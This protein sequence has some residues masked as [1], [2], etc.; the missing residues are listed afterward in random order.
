MKA[1]GYVESN[2]RTDSQ[3]QLTALDDTAARRAPDNINELTVDIIGCKGVKARQRG[4][5]VL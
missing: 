5:L 2:M 1:L 4:T 3:P